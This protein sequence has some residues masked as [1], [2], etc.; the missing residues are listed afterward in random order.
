MTPEDFAALPKSRQ[1][2][3][4][5]DDLEAKSKDDN[6]TIDMNRWH[7]QCLELPGQ[8]CAGCSMDRSERFMVDMAANERGAESTNY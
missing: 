6:Y 4:A 3:I 8:P 2:Q 5:I 1:I 7:H